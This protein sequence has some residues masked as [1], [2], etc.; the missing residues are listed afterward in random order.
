MQFIA[1]STESPNAGYNVSIT[2]I[3]L[4]YITTEIT[5]LKMLLIATIAIDKHESLDQGICSGRMKSR[6][7]ILHVHNG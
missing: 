1:H 6:T 2:I 4:P 5:R 3:V 7:P